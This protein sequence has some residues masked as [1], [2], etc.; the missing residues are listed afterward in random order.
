MRLKNQNIVIIGGGESGVGAAILAEKMGANVFVSDAGVLKDAY[1]SE[2][3]S[4]NVDYEESG[5][6]LDRILKADLVVKSPGI[7]NTVEVLQKLRSSGVLIFSEIVIKSSLCID[8]PFVNK[9]IGSF[10]L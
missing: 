5:H 10:F 9:T 4:L 8:R 7:P 6:D 2:L 1:R 3:H